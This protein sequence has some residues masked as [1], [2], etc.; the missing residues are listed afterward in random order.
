MVLIS[1]ASNRALGE[2]CMEKPL[3]TLWRNYTQNSKPDVSMRVRICPSGLKA[4][5]RQHGLTEYWSHRITF[6]SAPRNYPKVFCW[7]YRHEGRK[8]KHELRCHAVLCTKEPVAES[9]AKMLQVR[10]MCSTAQCP[11]KRVE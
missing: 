9:I 1:P 7:I 10:I 2:S 5:T 11:L 6:C 3:A 4:T 8:L